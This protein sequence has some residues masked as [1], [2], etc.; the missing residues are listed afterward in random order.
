MHPRVAGTN[1]RVPFCDFAGRG[2]LAWLAMPEFFSPKAPFRL[3]RSCSSCSPRMFTS[4]FTSWSKICPPPLSPH[5]RARTPCHSCAPH[6]LTFMF[7]GLKFAHPRSLHTRARTPCRSLRGRAASSNGVKRKWRSRP[8]STDPQLLRF[9][10]PWLC[11]CCP[12]P[13]SPSFPFSRHRCPRR[14][15]HAI[16]FLFFFWQRSR[17]TDYADALADARV[18]GGVGNGVADDMIAAEVTSADSLE[19]S[20]RV[21][22]LSDGSDADDLVARSEPPLATPPT[23][24]PAVPSPLPPRS[25]LSTGP[26]CGCR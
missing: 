9:A 23:P 14:M 2:P 11:L 15:H 20:L 19:D 1:S 26:C 5:T 7:H 4:C 12:M 6:M 17:D 22:D 13:S 24:S 10:L 18:H 25:P 16:F 3:G 21:L 8:E